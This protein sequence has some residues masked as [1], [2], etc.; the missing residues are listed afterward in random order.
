MVCDVL[1][2]SQNVINHAHT[3]PVSSFQTQK[4]SSMYLPIKVLELSGL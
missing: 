4:N 1:S 3:I 2:I